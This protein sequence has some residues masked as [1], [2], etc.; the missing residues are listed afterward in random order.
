MASELLRSEVQ[1]H[2]MMLKQAFDFQYIR[3]WNFFSSEF[4]IDV[5]NQNG[6][7]NF[8]RLDS[9]FDFLLNQYGSWNETTYDSLQPSECT[10]LR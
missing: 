5:D 10:D 4:L 1:E 6:N 2:V 3:F 7:Y 9:V 8:T